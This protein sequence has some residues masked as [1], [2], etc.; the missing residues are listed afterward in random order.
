MAGA[1]DVVGCR[2]YQVGFAALSLQG[3]PA[4]RV[5]SHMRRRAMRPIKISSWPLD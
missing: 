5:Q 3:P 1:Q 4:A 2:T